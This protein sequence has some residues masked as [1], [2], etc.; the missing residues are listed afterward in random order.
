MPRVS[1]VH[2]I[3]RAL[4]VSAPGESV[5]T[6]GVDDL[7]GEGVF[8]GLADL[9]AVIPPKA[10]ARP[11]LET[12]FGAVWVRAGVDVER[13]APGMRTQGRR[14]IPVTAPIVRPA[15]RIFCDVVFDPRLADRFESFFEI[16][17]HFF[18]HLE[19][20][21]FSIKTERDAHEL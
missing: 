16:I 7:Y 10:V 9:F 4:I 17:F 18:M 1:E 13:G 5:A 11:A 21:G 14:F 12:T 8:L 19:P 2:V 20:G 3:L 15:G 6:E